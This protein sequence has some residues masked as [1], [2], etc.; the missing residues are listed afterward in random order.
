MEMIVLIIIAIMIAVIVA[1][2][3]VVIE[4]QHEIA[5][6][7]ENLL[8]HQIILRQITNNNSKILENKIKILENEI[9][10]LQGNKEK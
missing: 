4:N 2:V 10:L 7:I 1:N 5:R 3:N 8:E 9:K 6:A